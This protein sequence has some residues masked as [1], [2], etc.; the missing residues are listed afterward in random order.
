MRYIHCLVFI[1]FSI[2]YNFLPMNIGGPLKG[3]S[4]T[5]GLPAG[6]GGAGWSGPG[7]NG[8]WGKQGGWHG[9]MRGGAAMHGPLIGP[10]TGGA[11][12]R[13][14]GWQGRGIHIGRHGGGLGQGLQGRHTIGQGGGGGFLGGGGG[15]GGDELEQQQQQQ[16]AECNKSYI[17]NDETNTSKI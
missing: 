5:T 15:G 12:M 1:V 10:G 11:G 4:T 8:F 13:H 6:I 14:G 7:K 3:W 16:Q 17:I 2:N 9:P